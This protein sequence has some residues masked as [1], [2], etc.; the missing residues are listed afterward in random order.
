MNSN[1]VPYDKRKPFDPSGIR[2]GT[3]A[4]TSRGFKEK[5]IILVSEFIDQVINNYE[6]EQFLMQTAKKV[7]ELCSTFPAP[8]LEHL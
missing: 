8:G 1:A 6:D 2:M 7:A 3:P 5:E 4:I